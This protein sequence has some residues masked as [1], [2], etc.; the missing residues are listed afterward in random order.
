MSKALKYVL[1][2]FVLILCGCIILVAEGLV[3]DLEV[4][5]NSIEVTATVVEAGD[6]KVTKTGTSGMKNHKEQKHYHQ[7]ITY[8]YEFDGEVHEVVEKGMSVASRGYKEGSEFTIYIDEDGN[9]YE[10]VY[11]SGKVA[12]FVF[13]VV[14]IVLILIVYIRRWSIGCEDNLW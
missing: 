14:F 9:V 6:I 10:H 12:M 5:K 4:I 11:T 13:I 2:V 8:E 7:D 3:Y 1:I